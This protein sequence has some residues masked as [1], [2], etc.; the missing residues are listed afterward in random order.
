MTTTESPN[1][2]SLHPKN[3]SDEEFSVYKTEFEKVLNDPLCKNIAL[4][5]PYG[6]GKSSVIEKL[7][8]KQTDHGEKWVTVS[9][10]TFKGA[11]E[12]E[13]TG[14]DSERDAVEAEILR[15]I[16]HKVGTSKAPKSRFRKLDDRKWFV[17]AGI[18]GAVLAFAILSAYLASAF[19]RLV[20]LQSSFLDQFAFA[21]WAIIVGLGLYQAVRSSAVSKFIKR[22]K[23]FDAEL[24]IT[25]KDSNS[26]PYERCVDEI[27]YLLNASEIDAVVFEDMDRFDSIDIFEKM[28]NLNGLSNDSRINDKKKSQEVKPLRFF[29]LVRDGLFDNP[30]DRTKFFDYVIPVVPYIDPNNALDIT[31]GALCNVGISVDGGFLY[32]LSSYIDDPRIAHEIADEAF[33]YKAA[34]L[35][36]R[37]P[38]DGDLERLVAILA[39]KALFPKDFELLQVGRGYLHEVLCGKQR[40]ITS[41][42]K[43]NKEKRDE[44]YSELEEIEH[45][46]EASEDELICMYGAPQINGI[47]R[48]TNHN[49]ENFDPH[50]FLEDVRSN[51]QFRYEIE[52]LMEALKANERFQQ[53]KLEAR[54][55]ANRRSEVIRSQ[56][57]KIDKQHALLR[58][59][60]I[61]ELVDEL[62]NAD[63]LFNFDRNEINR[64]EDYEELSMEAVLNNPSFP[65]IRFLVSSGWIDESYN[66]YISIFYSESLC[67]EDDVFLSAIKQAKPIDLEYKPKAPQEIIR[68]MDRG[69]FSRESIRNPWL[70]SALFDTDDSEKIDLFMESVKRSG[71]IQYLAQFIASEQFNPKIFVELFAHYDDPFT[72]LLNDEGISDNDKR[73]FCKRYL[74]HGGD[75][76]LSD[77]PDGAL[78]K[79]ISNDP[80]FLEEDSRFED[81]TIEKGIRAIGYRAEAIDF[82]TASRVLLDYV[83]ENRLFA[84]NAFVIDGFLRLEQGA[85]EHMNNGTLITVAF[86]QQNGP[87]ND[88]VF[89][90]LDYFVSSVMREAQ[91]PLVDAPECVIAVLNNE[92]VRNETAVSYIGAL[93]GVEIEDAAQVKSPKYR[94]L[95]LTFQLVECNAW[96]II[97][98]YKWSDNSISDKLAGLIEHKGAP[99][100]LD[101]EKCRT[102]DVDGCDIIRQIVDCSEISVQNKKAFL[103]ECG[104]SFSSYDIDSLSDETIRAMLEV[105]AIDMNG[106]MLDKFRLLKPNLILDYIFSDID[107]F[108][109]LVET[110]S[111][112]ESTR[113]IEESE[114]LGLLSASID[115]EKKLDALSYFNGSISL[116]PDY[117]EAVNDAIISEHFSQEDVPNLPFY[118]QKRSGM[119]KKL[120]AVKVAECS[121]AAIDEEVNLGWDLLCD[122]L[123][124]LKED[125]VRALQLLEMFCRCY[126]TEGDRSHVLRCFKAAGLEEYIKLIQKSQSLIP[127]SDA[128]DSMLLAMVNL[129]MC[130][131]ISPEINSEGL[132]R[133]Y[134][135]GGKR[136]K[137]GSPRL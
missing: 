134:S 81:S 119:S 114:L 79:Y 124:A 118:Y 46:L 59:M 72:E 37:K 106:E 121:G 109:S 39:Y 14:T 26:S 60:S 113:D 86:R 40:L 132:R 64:G 9:L 130:G 35:D 36:K 105:K 29:Y 85:I 55:D 65:M 32:Q 58:A 93:E 99:N 71:G 94:N 135:K 43:T 7:K 84:P 117:E 50:A 52:S 98:Y 8:K 89:R 104:F 83:Y 12:K 92:N 66:R 49:P 115:V 128:D 18:A 69:M 116:N 102:A 24:E 129:Q 28:R 126:A 54:K 25:P 45:Q 95:L 63:A 100:G 111:L 82:T 127:V 123:N 131:T 4:S 97:S 27:V 23:I 31:K 136:P 38:M 42:E 74:A 48:Y 75:S 76:L 10:A 56:I 17:D 68:R 6:A 33:H 91:A 137:K 44:L 88:V 19:E 110:D 41:F 47:S 133:V 70:V 62:P 16:V 61:K 53:R 3:L 120:I 30:H 57:D 80:R 67:A 51:S 1:L 5:G 15:Q 107:G 73:C 21:A 125:R 22:I 87:I 112:G 122:A 101:L 96:N 78:A 108:L 90:D 11:N 77:D 103:Q 20:N 34:L 2:L 13:Q